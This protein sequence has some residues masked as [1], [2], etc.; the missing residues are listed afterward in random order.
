M[1]I[2]RGIAMLR[3]I[4]GLFFCIKKAAK[5][6]VVYKDY[7]DRGVT[8]RLWARLLAKP[9]KTFFANELFEKQFETC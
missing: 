2:W 6:H 9:Q 1:Q 7:A 3:F 4:N 5:L 8:S